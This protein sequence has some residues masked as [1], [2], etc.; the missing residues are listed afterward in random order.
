MMARI[1]LEEEQES[2]PEMVWLMLM[3]LLMVL[4]AKLASWFVGGLGTEFM[5]LSVY[6]CGRE[7]VLG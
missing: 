1:T 4:L 3:G 2:E 6:H 5:L 7:V